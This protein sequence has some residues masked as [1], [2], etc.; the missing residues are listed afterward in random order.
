M[1]N[2]LLVPYLVHEAEMTRQERTIR[3]L[4][5]L[6]L[7]IFIAFVG[8]NLAWIIYESQFEVLET[9]TQQEITQESESGD[10]Y[11]VAVGG[12]YYGETDH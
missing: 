5:I 12:D 1:D 6:C 7:V 8:S 9:T 4:F 2:N 10:N 11:A 3:R